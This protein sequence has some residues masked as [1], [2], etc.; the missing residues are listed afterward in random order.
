[1]FRATVTE[2]SG[3][4]WVVSL[5]VAQIFHLSS[6]R[7]ISRRRA[8]RDQLPLKHNLSHSPNADSQSI[9]ALAV[10]VDYATLNRVPEC[11]GQAAQIQCFF[12]D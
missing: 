9:S 2:G 11:T 12:F 6:L 4:G 8:F 7:R 5:D 3:S 1:M 10:I